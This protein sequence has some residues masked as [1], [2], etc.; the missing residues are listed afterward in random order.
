MQV[1]LC[2]FDVLVAAP[3]RDHCG[4]DAGLQQSHRGGVTQ[5]VGSDPF[6]AQGRAGCSGRGDVLGEAV[7]DGVA[8]ETSAV[9]AG[10]ERIG[11]LALISLSLIRSVRTVLVAKGV[12]RCLRPLPVQVTWAPVPR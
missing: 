6:A 10:E 3:E 7:F 5:G 4:V 9:T 8:A 12:V 1:D 11:G 2:G